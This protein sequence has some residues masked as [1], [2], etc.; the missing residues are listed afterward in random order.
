M[1]PFFRLGKTL[2]RSIID[3]KK[4]NSL[5]LDGTSEIHL[6]ASIR[7]MD[8]FMEMNNGRIVTMFDLGRYDL[9]VRT[10]LGKLLLKNRWGL[11]VAGSSIQY[12]KRIRPMD[13]VTI[14]TRLTGIDE[15][16]FYIEQS[17]WANGVPTSAILL[18]TGITNKGRA[19]PTQTVLD[20][21]GEPNFRLPLSEWVQAWANADKLRVFPTAETSTAEQ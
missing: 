9:S 12:R 19:L 4:G 2:A 8:N 14:K 3:T 5:P 21:L 1:Y 10:G 16:W 11:V 6:K 7:D 18:R 20:A 17:M 13:K 15:R